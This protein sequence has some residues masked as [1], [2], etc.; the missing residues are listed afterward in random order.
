MTQKT[1]IILN[2][3]IVLLLVASLFSWPTPVYAGDSVWS[4]ETIPGRLG[5]SIGPASIDIRDYAIGDDDRTIYAVPGDSITDNVVFKS[6]NAGVSW[7]ALP[8][9]IRADL[10]AVAPEIGRAH[11]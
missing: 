10:V 3:S 11:V 9:S 6:S 4:A 1:A 2:L 7:T 5:N 8:V